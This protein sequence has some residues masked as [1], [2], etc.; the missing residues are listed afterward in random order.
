MTTVWLNGG[1]VDESTAHVSV[2]DTGLLHGIGV[3]TT[4]RAD[5]GTIRSIDSHLLR[6]RS[7]CEAF[8]IPLTY[9]NDE[10]KAAAATLLADNAFPSARLR[11]TV[12]RG[13][14]RSDPKHGVI[15]EPTVLLTATQLE[16]Y[17]QTL[18]SN[19]MT[20]LAYDTFKL[21]PYDPQAGHKTLDYLSRFTALRDA[22]QHG[23]NEAILFNVHNFLQSGAMSNV[24]LVKDGKLLTPPTQA[25]LHDGPTQARTPYPRS[26]VLPGIVRG[27]VLKLASLHEIEVVLRG[28]TIN[29]LLEAEEVFLTN[30]IMSVMPVCR[31]ERKEIG[32]GK[33]GEITKQLADAYSFGGGQ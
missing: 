9:T 1:L 27:D 21:N 24:F 19:G 25:E 32:S 8:A 26:N 29:D 30:S 18:Y 33:P 13:S 15:L 14:Q 20:V 22:Q 6:I 5:G 10:L 11:L 2:R 28:L 12:T 4:M 31:I 16:P 3:F 7:S 23:A 17:P